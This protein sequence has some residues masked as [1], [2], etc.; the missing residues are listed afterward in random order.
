MSHCY[1][2]ILFLDAKK[3]ILKNTEGKFCYFSE[4]NTEYKDVNYRQIL[5]RSL[6]TEYMVEL[7]KKLKLKDLYPKLPKKENEGFL[8][9]WSALI[10]VKLTKASR[11]ELYTDEGFYCNGRKYVRY[12]RSASSAKTGNCLFI[13]ER[14]KEKMDKWNVCG[15]ERPSDFSKLTSFEAYSALTLSSIQGTFKLPKKSIL[16]VRD[17]VSEFHAPAIAVKK[18]EEGKLVPKYSDAVPFQNTIW[19][20]ECL[21]DESVF[22]EAVPEEFKTSSMLLLR[23]RFFKSC[24]FRTKLAKWFQDNNITSVSSLNGYT[25]AKKI[26]DIK[27]VITESSLK[28]LKFSPHKEQKP[29][30]REDFTP[31]YY[32]E[33]YNKYLGLELQSWFKGL[34]GEHQLTFGIVKTDSPSRFFN[35]KMVHTN[36]QLLNTLGLNREE[37]EHLLSDT[38]AYLEKAKNDPAFFHFYLQNGLTLSLTNEDS[39]EEETEEVYEEE[40]SP[41]HSDFDFFHYQKKAVMQLLGFSEKTFHTSLCKKVKNDLMEDAKNQIAKGRFLIPGTFGILFGNPIELLSF[42]ID[43]SY[44]LPSIPATVSVA[45]VRYPVL[46]E[47]EIYSSMF[48]DKENLCCARSPH[49]TMGNL[50][51]GVN[52]Y[53]KNKSGESIFKKYFTLS[54]QIVCVN[55]IGH[56]LLDRLN[57][58]DFDSD[59]MLLTNQPVMVG[60][61][62]R[63]GDL[64]PVPKYVKEAT[65]CQ[66]EISTEQSGEWEQLIKI[67]TMLANNKIGS[68]INLSQLLN[69]IFWTRYPNVCRVESEKMKAF[70]VYFEEV[71]DLICKAAG[72][73]KVLNDGEIMIKSMSLAYE[74]STYFNSHFPIF[75]FLFSNASLTKWI[76]KEWRKLNEKY[77]KI[78]EKG[79]V[80]IDKTDYESPFKLFLLTIKD[81]L[82]EKLYPSSYI[83]RYYYEI[84]ETSLYE[85]ICILEVLSNLEI[86]KAKRIDFNNTLAIL[87]ESEEFSNLY[88]LQLK[89]RKWIVPQIP[90]YLT[91]LLKK[92]KAENPRPVTIENMKFE[93]NSSKAEHTSTMR[94]V[95]D[96][97]MEKI[98]P[99]KRKETIPLSEILSPIAEKKKHTEIFDRIKIIAAYYYV[100]IR[101]SNRLSSNG[102]LASDYG[103]QAYYVRECYQKITAKILGQKEYSPEFLIFSLLKEMDDREEGFTPAQLALKI[104]KLGAAGQKNLAFAKDLLKLLSSLGKEEG[105][106]KSSKKPFKNETY[107]GLLTS[108]LCNLIAENEKIRESLFPSSE[109]GVK[110]VMFTEKGT[111]F[112]LYNLYLRP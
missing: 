13:D 41:K 30:F 88:Q 16:I 59:T 70:K 112:S 22:L 92:D 90:D 96:I 46:K 39:C 72:D 69:S 31:K 74:L 3:D 21:I 1:Y 61:L 75:A 42:I 95:Y 37:S 55:S 35:G 25:S 11:K 93:P 94:Y 60:A 78:Q 64:F 12:R 15:L 73:V 53:L 49:I 6:D 84:S 87:K 34:G 63:Q 62:L 83:D 10:N 24:G 101:T 48:Q 17:L 106:P 65:P 32:A 86:D 71:S 7:C 23:N 56:T 97:A 85:E 109:E 89:D 76:H 27:I 18:S 4:E 111:S 79:K 58:A 26:E 40:N 28:Y 102:K 104:E 77:L 52:K 103:K 50:F 80:N 47:N 68:I 51:P 99:A 38:L 110:K 33:K 66:S 82:F 98:L 2:K 91:N 44:V 43:K 19:D 5:E 54:D 45:G 107:R 81:S 57:G 36:Y 20:G 8:G 100:K 105:K 29:E 9:F 108:A 67:D 14:L